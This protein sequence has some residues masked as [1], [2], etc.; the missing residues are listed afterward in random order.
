MFQSE[1][2]PHCSDIGKY[3]P[4]PPRGVISSDVNWGEKYEK[5][6]RKKR[7]IR[8]VNVKIQQ[9]KGKLK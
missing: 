5:G 2:Q 7:Q 4:S 6:K 3:P 1:N 9:I 8:R